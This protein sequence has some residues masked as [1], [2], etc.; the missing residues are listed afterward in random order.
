MKYA[1]IYILLVFAAVL[2]VS[3]NNEDW[4]SPIISGGAATDT[5][6]NIGD[7]LVLAPD[8]TNLK[9]ISYTWLV[10]GKEVSSGE[11]YYMFTATEPGNFIVTLRATNKGGTNEQLFKILVEEPI[12]VTLENGLSTPMCKVLSIKPAITGPERDD[13][14]YEWAIGD[15]I[16]GQTETLEFIAVNAGDYTLTLTAKAGKQSSSANCQVKVEEAEYID[17]AYN[18]LEYYPSPAQ[19]HNWSIIGT[20]SNWKYGYEHPLSYT[21]FLAKATELKKENGYQGL[22]IGSWGGY[23]TFQ[24]DHTIAD[25]PGKTDLEINAT[26]AN[27][28]V[29]T[30][31]VGYDRNQNGKPDEDEWYEIKNNDYGMED[32][33]EYEI[34]FTYLKID[35][36]T[37][38]KKANIYF[39][40]KDNQETPQE[41]EV[42]YNMTYKKA[43]T[44]EGTLSTKGFFPGYY[45]K[46]KESKEVVLLDGWKSS[47][48]RKGKRITKDVTG[49]VYRYQKLNVDIAMAVNTKGEP[50]DLPGIDFVKVRK[51]VYPFVEE[52]GVKK[53]FNMDEK[54]MIEVN[55]IID[56][57]LILKK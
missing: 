42:A 12:A 17:N 51:S 15:S 48:S 39:G 46:D 27:A 28:D 38:E 36:V 23:A 9:D 18:V 49:S 31:Y 25:V 20:S 1:I 41:G 16:I 45:M 34:T 21:E 19:G 3:C 29:P 8:I 57:H 22:I 47:F 50:V 44:I 30:V 55:S 14:E 53:D 37:N 10:N 52:K 26:Y 2:T 56:K 40:W 24:F 32:I 7:K 6:L 35:I 11:T 5:T 13:Y 43:L 54:R 33:P 4:P